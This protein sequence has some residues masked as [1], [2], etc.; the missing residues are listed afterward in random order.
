MHLWWIS[1]FGSKCHAK[2]INSYILKHSHAVVVLFIL[3]TFLLVYNA[4]VP[5]MNS[6]SYKNISNISGRLT[7]FSECGKN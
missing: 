4:I 6:V 7:E 1:S 5:H 3:C 2:L